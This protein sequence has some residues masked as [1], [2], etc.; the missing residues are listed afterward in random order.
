[1]TERT[2]ALEGLEPA[3][4]IDNWATED[5]LRQSSGSEVRLQGRVYPAG[6]IP[7]PKPA[8]LRWLAVLGP[9][10]VA[11]SAGNDAGGI[12]TYSSAGA[13]YGYDLIDQV[14]FTCER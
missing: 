7:R 11:A 13:K 4:Q 10:L 5:A 8:W 3:E 12:A 2:P 6:R 14:K 9:G 1:M